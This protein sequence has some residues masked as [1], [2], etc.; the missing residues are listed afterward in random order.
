MKISLNL[1]KKY[2]EIPNDKTKEQIAYDL[3]MRTVEVEEIIDYK[4]KYKN[5]VVGKIEEIKEHPNADSLRICRVNVGKD[6]YQIVCGGTNLYINEYVIVALPRIN[7]CMA[8]RR[9]ACRNKE[10]RAKRNRK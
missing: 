5:I 1:V 8:W 3:T 9:R 2:V 4:E 7:G 6:T 10:N